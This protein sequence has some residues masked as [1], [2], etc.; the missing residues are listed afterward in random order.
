VRFV[1]LSRPPGSSSSALR[2]LEA[3]PFTHEESLGGK[4]VEDLLGL[5]EL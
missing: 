3:V 1:T 2:D 4:L 5:G